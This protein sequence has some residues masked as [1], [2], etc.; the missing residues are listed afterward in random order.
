MHHGLVPQ[1]A[2]DRATAEVLEDFDTD[3]AR[4]V[5]GGVANAMRN[6]FDALS[7]TAFA[8]RNRCVADAG[9]RTW[10]QRG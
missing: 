8:D 7:A 10:T 1:L 2:R 4:G 6:V 5:H 3:R 9:L